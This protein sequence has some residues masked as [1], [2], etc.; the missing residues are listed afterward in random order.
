MWDYKLEMRDCTEVMLGYKLVTKG[1]IE[2][3]LDCIWVMLDYTPATSGCT[4]VMLDC[5]M[6]RWGCI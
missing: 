4:E 5:R 6:V 1:C 2:V 3:M